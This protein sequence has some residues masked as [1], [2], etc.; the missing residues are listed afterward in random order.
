MQ[1]LD[2][3]QTSLRKDPLGVDIRYLLD[4]AAV[5]SAS[6]LRGDD[7]AVSALAELLDELVLPVDDEG[8]VECGEAVPLQRHGG[9]G[10]RV[11][12]QTDRQ[13]EK[14]AVLLLG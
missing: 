11:G 7:A 13:T 1:Q 5:A 6:V 4:R 12:G 10:C 2:L 14:D 9:L 3:A 8:R